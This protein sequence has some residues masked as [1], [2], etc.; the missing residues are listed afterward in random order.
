MISPPWTPSRYPGG[1]YRSPIAACAHSPVMAALPG[2]APCVRTRQPQPPGITAGNN[3]LRACTLWRLCAWTST[4]QPL[5]S[6][7]LKASL[8][9]GYKSSSSAPQKPSPHMRHM[10]TRAGC[11]VSV[12]A[13]R[14]AAHRLCLRQPSSP[15]YIYS[16]GMYKCHAALPMQLRGAW[17]LALM[18]LLQRRQRCGGC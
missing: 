5:K 10:R 15:R 7:V 3:M 2:R 12:Q 11:Q 9:G 4:C 8:C 13:A 17:H 6:A 14:G 16:A 18:P 1:S